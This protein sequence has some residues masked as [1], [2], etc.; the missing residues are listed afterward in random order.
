MAMDSLLVEPA[1][2]FEGP[3]CLA[4]PHEANSSA[5][6]Q[7]AEGSAGQS[8]QDTPPTPAS[9]HVLPRGSRVRVIGNNRTKCSLVGLEGVVRK[10]VGLGGWHWLVSENCSYCNSNAHAPCPVVARPTVATGQNIQVPRA[11]A[12]RT[13]P[14]SHSRAHID[15]S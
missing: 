7:T 3:P 10:S 13:L 6:S 4:A 1:S 15:T 8:R 5:S 9:F 14:P 12:P 11:P 2:T